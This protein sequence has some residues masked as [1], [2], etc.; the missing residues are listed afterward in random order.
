MLII[1]ATA[2]AVAT[3][4]VTATEEAAADRLSHMVHRIVMVSSILI[5]ITHTIEQCY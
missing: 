1:T 4:V 2:V 3:I 5:L